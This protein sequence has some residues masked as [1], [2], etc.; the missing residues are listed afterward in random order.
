MGSI[1]YLLMHVAYGG[2]QGGGLK[3]IRYSVNGSSWEDSD[4]PSFYEEKAGGSFIHEINQNVKGAEVRACVVDR[5][6]NVS[7]TVSARSVPG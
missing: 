1:T 2:A 7:N 4:R 6:G 3:I 5:A